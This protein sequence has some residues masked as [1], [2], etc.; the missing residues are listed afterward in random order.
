MRAWAGEERRKQRLSDDEIDLI[1]ERAASK[2]EERL[3]AQIGRSLVSKILWLL[4]AAGAAVLAALG[5]TGHW[6]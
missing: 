1:A 4:G 6:K 5:I 2:V 3:Y